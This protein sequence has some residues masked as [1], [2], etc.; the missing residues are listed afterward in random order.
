MFHRH[1]G[2]NVW[3]FLQA[4]NMQIQVEVPSYLKINSEFTPSNRVVNP[5]R[6]VYSLLYAPFFSGVN[7][8]LIS[9]RVTLEQ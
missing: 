6:N 7:S 2:E 8:L 4:S 3:N 9:G 1:L 5:K